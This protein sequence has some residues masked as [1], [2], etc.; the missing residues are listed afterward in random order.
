MSGLFFTTSAL[1]PSSEIGEVHRKRCRKR[2]RNPRP[3]HSGQRRAQ[4]QQH[5]RPRQ[6]AERSVSAAPTAP[7]REHQPFRQHDGQDQI[8]RMALP[9]QPEPDRSQPNGPL[10]FTIIMLR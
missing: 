9:K 4:R 6:Q 8:D 3:R 7:A 2:E 1:R 5:Q 10:S